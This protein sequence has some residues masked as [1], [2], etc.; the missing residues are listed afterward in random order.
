M[1]RPDIGEQ[2]GEALKVRRI[3]IRDDV[4]ISGRTDHAVRV[5]RES[6][7]DDV[8]LPGLGECPEQRLRVECIRHALR[9]R[10]KASAN[11]LANSV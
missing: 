1:P 7:D 11:R 2:R 3:R 10:L 4:Q 9:A 6:P 5:H 8:L